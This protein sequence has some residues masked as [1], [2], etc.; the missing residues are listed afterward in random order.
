MRNSMD[1]T[2]IG[3]S[4]RV[5]LCDH[6]V[7]VFAK[8]D[9]GAYYSSIDADFIEVTEGTLRYRLF[10]EGKEGYDPRIIETKEF[11]MLTARSSNGHEQTRPM[12]QLTVELAGAK[13][14]AWFSLA[15]REKMF[16]PILVG[17]NI[18]RENYII[19]VTKG[20]MAPWDISEF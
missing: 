12:I 20:V 13:H 19:D 16:Y 18:L 2:L 1:K 4:E 3:R 11:E 14:A 9:S 5:L 10:H 6:D 17:R 15:N 7:E 8:I